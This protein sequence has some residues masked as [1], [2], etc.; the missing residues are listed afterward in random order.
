[1]DNDKGKSKGKGKEKGSKGERR[2]GGK[3]GG[4]DGE[5]I[6]KCRFYLSETGCR[7]GRACDWSHDQSD[8]RR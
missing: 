7:K 6:P 2:D 8:G 3:G 4:G 5:E 1:M